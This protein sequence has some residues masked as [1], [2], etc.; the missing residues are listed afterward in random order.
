[1]VV[2]VEEEMAEVQMALMEAQEEKIMAGMA[3]ITPQVR[4]V[5]QVRCLLQEVMRVPEQMVVVAAAARIIYLP[6]TLSKLPV[7]ME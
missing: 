5:E 4:A 3:G 2:V 6:S 1:M 7:E